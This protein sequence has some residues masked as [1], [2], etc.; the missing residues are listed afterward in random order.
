MHARYCLENIYNEKLFV[1]LGMVC[2]YKMRSS[3]LNNYSIDKSITFVCGGKNWSFLC[4]KDS[5]GGYISLS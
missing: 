5:F 4:P 2:P 3:R 1:D